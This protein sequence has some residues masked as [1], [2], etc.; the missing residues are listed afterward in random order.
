MVLLVLAR[1]WTA[2]NTGKQQEM[3]TRSIGASLAIAMAMAMVM[4]LLTTLVYQL[5]RPSSPTSLPIAMC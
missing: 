1:P 5:A 2:H 4:S 3:P